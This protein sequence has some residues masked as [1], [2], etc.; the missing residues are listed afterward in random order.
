MRT[1]PIVFN[2]YVAMIYLVASQFPI[3]KY[4]QGF[5]NAYNE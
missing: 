4:I 3:G 5:C 1:L 2:Q